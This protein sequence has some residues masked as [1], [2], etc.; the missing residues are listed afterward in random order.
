MIR[1]HYF[2]QHKICVWCS[3]VI[4]MDWSSKSNHH[5]PQW[6]AIFT[7]PKL[8]VMTNAHKTKAYVHLTLISRFACWQNLLCHWV[9]TS[10]GCFSNRHPVLT[11]GTGW[12]SHMWEPDWKPIFGSHMNKNWS[13]EP[14]HGVFFLKNWTGSLRKLPSSS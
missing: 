13:W 2:S 10:V 1:N 14:V 9:H 4:K 7:P 3:C 8:Q 12:C 5:M 6:F 11:V